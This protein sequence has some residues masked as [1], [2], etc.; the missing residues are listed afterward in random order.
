MDPL[1]FTLENFDAIGKWRILDESGNP[2]DVS[3]SLVD[4]TRLNGPSELRKYLLRHRENFA[5]TFTEK[6][7]TYALGRGLEYYDQP[8][9]RKIGRDAAPHDFRWSAIIL[10][11]VKSAPFQTRSVQETGTQPSATVATPRAK[12][13]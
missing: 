8:T 11:V 9:I 7:L 10:G 6:L 1:G 5:G 3:G 13:K 2:V 4:G 12:G